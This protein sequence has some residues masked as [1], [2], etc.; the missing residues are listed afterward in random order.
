MVTHARRKAPWGR[1]LGLALIEKI[2]FLSLLLLG[3]VVMVSS[4]E[5]PNSGLGQAMQMNGFVN[6]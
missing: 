6:W 2:L 4:L 5:V 3:V 1:L